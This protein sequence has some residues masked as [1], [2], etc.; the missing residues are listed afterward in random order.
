MQKRN[1]FFILAGAQSTGKTSVLLELKKQNQI[2]IDE[3]ARRVIVN[4]RRSGDNATADYDKQSYCILQH[5]TMLNDYLTHLTTKE[6]IFFDRG[7]PDSIFTEKAINGKV[8]NQTLIDIE[9]HRY[10]H[11]VFLFPPW[12]KCY[13]KDDIRPGDFNQSIETHHHII[14]AYKQAD[15]ELI[16]MPTVS[17]IQRVQFILNRIPS[18]LQH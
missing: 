1:N 13:Q 2:T 15:Y 7:L 6:N 14:S 4:Q 11:H 5:Q 18:F 10:N 16:T 9:E 8:R 3:A 12:I 17:V